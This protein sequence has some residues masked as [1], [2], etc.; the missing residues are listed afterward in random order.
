M[1][2]NTSIFSLVFFALLILGQRFQCIEARY[3]K[4][5][6]SNQVLV[7]HNKD[8][9]NTHIGVSTSN[10][11]TLLTSGSVDDFRPTEPGH[12]PGVGHSIHD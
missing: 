7:K 8:E 11:S 2:Q 4:S 12:S 1:A 9:G 6:E 5:N 10:V 3:L